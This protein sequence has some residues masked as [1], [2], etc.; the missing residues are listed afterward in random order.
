MA[1]EAASSRENQVTKPNYAA[2]EIN[3]RDFP[4]NA[5]DL[6]KLRFLA[7]YA[8]LAPSGHNTQPWQFGQVGQT[9]TVGVDPRRNLAH[10]GCL[11]ASRASASAHASEYSNWPP[12]GLATTFASTP[13]PATDQ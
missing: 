13:C 5:D 8:I 10:S 1:R 4:D 2:W 6:S 3:P 11:L 9:L 7:R 12:A